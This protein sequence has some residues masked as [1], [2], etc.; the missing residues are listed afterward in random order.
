MT[1][2]S[3][4]LLIL[5]HFVLIGSFSFNTRL[6]SL[7]TWKQSIISDCDWLCSQSS[8]TVLHANP[9]TSEGSNYGKYTNEEDAFLWFDEA[10]FYVRAGSGGAGSNAV[11]FGAGRQ[12]RYPT[13]GNGGNGGNIYLVAD[14]NV[15]TLLGFRG[16]SHFRAENGIDGALEYSNGKVGKD[17]YISVPK[18]IIIKDNETNAVIG[19]LNYVGDKILVAKGGLGG[20]GKQLM[21]VDIITVVPLNNLT[22]TVYLYSLQSLCFYFI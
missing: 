18:G 8:N 16:S 12:H 14:S 15:N 21:I 20:R 19:E 6:L 9:V 3:S 5:L 4:S 10:L 1:L 7:Y 2:I 13:G 22:I 11:K 17:F